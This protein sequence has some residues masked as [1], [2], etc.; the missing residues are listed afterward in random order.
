MTS[1][2]MQ[3]ATSNQIALCEIFTNVLFVVYWTFLQAQKR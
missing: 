1:D 3:L 2:Y